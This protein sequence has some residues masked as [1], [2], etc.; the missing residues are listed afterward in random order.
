[1]AISRFRIVMS[2]FAAALLAP[3]TSGAQFAVKTNLLYDATTTPN[4]GAEMAISRKST[5]NA[6][7]GLNPWTFNDGRKAKHWV[8]MPEYRWWTCT[9]FNGHFF[10][11]HALGGQFNAA[12]VDLPIPGFF[13]SGDNLRKEVKDF[14]YDA[15]YAGAGLTY[16]YQWSITRHFNIEAE[17]GLGY[18]HAQYDKYPCAKCG[19]RIKKGGANYAG[20]TKIGLSLLYIF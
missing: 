6:V 20:L 2:I 18:V 5:I 11:V 17:I 16:G 19:S 3:L 10:G 9:A 4:L 12:K 8:V 14:H 7:Y 15:W 13:F 1:M